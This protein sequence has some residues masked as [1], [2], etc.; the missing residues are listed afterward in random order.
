MTTAIHVTRVTN[1]ADLCRVT[2]GDEVD[3]IVRTT[4]LADEDIRQ[5]TILDDDVRGRIDR[6]HRRTCVWNLAVRMLAP[7]D[8]PRAV[9]SSR[10]EARGHHRDDVRAA[11][12]AMEN[13][14]LL[15][16]A[17]AARRSA[18]THLKRSPESPDRLIRRLETLGIETATA[19]QAVEEVMA[20]V[21]TAD[22]LARAAA[23]A[24]RGLDG[25]PRDTAVR[26][27]AGRLARRGWSEDDIT[28]EL[29][30]RWPETPHPHCPPHTDPPHPSPEAT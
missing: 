17:R 3:A 12:D 8:I 27:F 6:L 20:D 9:L 10:L 25:L 24:A 7:R 29:A 1:D 22:L 5:G 18:Q 28:D 16:D 11:L 14:G 13:A 23:K 15:D 21:E 19:Q 26:R 30:R 2:A 4:W